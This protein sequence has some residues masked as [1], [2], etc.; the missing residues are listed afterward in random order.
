MP[1]NAPATTPIPMPLRNERIAPVFDGSKPRELTRFFEDLEILMTRAQITDQQEMKKQVLRYVDFD[2]EQIWK[3]FTEYTDNTSAYQK[4]KD[5]I[6]THYPD[7]SGDFIYSLRDMDQLIGERQRIG[8]TT[9][10]DLSAYHL[11]FIA[12]T[13]WLISKGQLGDLEQQRAYV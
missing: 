1:P 6:L 9:T 4:F 2:T 8:I 12:I 7:A 5:A 10:Q 11:Q 13:I 3:T